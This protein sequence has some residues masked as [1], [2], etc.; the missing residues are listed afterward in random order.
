MGRKHTLLL[1]S[2]A[3]PVLALL[4]CGGNG[5]SSSSSS[6]GDSSSSSGMDGGS[7]GSGGGPGDPVNTKPTFVGAITSTTYD[8]M[9]DD[10]LTAGLGKSGLQSGTA[11][12]LAD[13]LAPTPAELRRL[14]IY[15]NYRA[16]IDTNPAGGFGVLF[17]P[18]IDTNGAPTLGEGKIPGVEHIAYSDDGS[19]HIN[20]TMM[21]QVP[22]AFDPKNP[23]IVTATSSGSR[24]VYGAIGT[25]GEW[26]LKHGCAVAYTDKGTG[27]GVYDLQKNTVNLITGVRQDA[28]VAGAASNFTAALTDADRAAFNAATPDR[29]SVKHAHSQQNPEHDWGTYTLQAIKFAFY[30][31]NEE[32]GDPV[33]GGSMRT[34]KLKPDN[35]IVIASSVSN[36]AGAA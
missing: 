9:T 17:G 10:L 13:P 26:G 5:G 16:L 12:P 25:A 20:V 6:S 32:F 27:N 21:V 11:P 33:A 14:A 29:F 19:G 4:A 2:A 30:V 34:Q 7:D 23:C 1:C 3:L 8:G 22:S 15:T 31:L 28:A 36:G 24:G 35:T 18:N